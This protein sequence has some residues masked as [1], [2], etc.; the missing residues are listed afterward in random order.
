[1]QKIIVFLSI[2]CCIGCARSLEPTP[3]NINKIFSSKDFTFEFNTVDGICKSISF[4]NDYLVYKSDAPTLR[5]EILYD[6]VILINDYIQKIVNLHSDTLDRDT[7]S[8][9]VIK[10]TAYKVIIVPNQE[11]YYFEALVKTL[12]LHPTQNK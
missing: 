5:R 6:E 10:N 12:K 3:E 4:R 11:D 9:Y 2:I 7:S 8:Y 1:M